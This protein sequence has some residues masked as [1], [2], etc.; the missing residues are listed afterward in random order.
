MDDGD[1]DQENRSSQNGSSSKTSMFE[2]V[3]PPYAR[4]FGHA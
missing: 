2:I 3:L 4:R 1:I